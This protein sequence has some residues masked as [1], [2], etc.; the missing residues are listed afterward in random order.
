MV[1]GYVRRNE[2]PQQNMSIL[3]NILKE[4]IQKLDSGINSDIDTKIRAFSSVGQSS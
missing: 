4:A 2:L 1:S 3:L